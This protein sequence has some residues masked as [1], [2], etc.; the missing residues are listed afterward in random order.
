MAEALRLDP[1]SA[2]KPWPSACRLADQS[3]E[4]GVPVSRRGGRRRAGAEGLRRR[5][6]RAQRVRVTCA[7]PHRR[8]DA[9]GRGVRGRRPRRLDARRAG[10]A[11][12]RVSR[13]R[14]LA[15]SA[16]HQRGPGRP[17]AV[18]HARTSIA[19]AARST[20]LGEPRPGHDHRRATERREPV[21]GGRQD[22]SATKACSS[23]S[24][25]PRV[26]PAPAPPKPP[27]APA[28]SDDEDV[29]DLER[30]CSRNPPLAPA[31]PAP[32]A[33]APPP[34]RRARS[35]TAAPTRTLTQAFKEMRDEV[36]TGSEEEAAAEQFS[37]AQTYRE[38][39]MIDDAIEA[40]KAAVR[41]PRQRFDAACLLGSLHV[42]R[43]ELQSA[44]EW[45]E[46][47]AEVPAPS[48][49]AGRASDVRLGQ[50]A[51]EGRRAVARARG[52]RRARSRIRQL[53]RRGVQD[54]AIVEAPGQ[55]VIRPVQTSSLRR[56]APR[57]RPAADPDSVVGVLGTELLRRSTAASRALLT[58]NFVRGA[59]SGLGLVNVLAAVA[60]LADH[61]WRAGAAGR[62]WRTRRAS[63]AITMRPEPPGGA[64]AVRHGKPS[65]PAAD[66]MPRSPIDAVSTGA[67]GIAGEQ[68]RA[69]LL[70]QI[71]APIAGGIDVV[72]IRERD[73]DDRV[74]SRHSSATVCARAAG[75][76]TRIV[77]NNRIDVARA[78]G[79][80]G[81]HLREDGIAPAAARRLAASP[82]LIG[83]SVHSA[84]AALASDGRGLPDRRAGVRDALESQVTPGMGVE[85]F[86]GIAAAAPCPGMGRR[87]DHAG[88]R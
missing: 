64:P 61:V 22:G 39:G 47:A 37:L 70:Q 4:S 7:E 50:H 32:V 79:A 75:T 12:R 73:L 57:S 10:A 76:R 40:L 1:T 5:R 27:A 69:A 87:R 16:H 2:T 26:E 63:S 74:L 28:A 38:L 84:D 44:I 51:R 21:H 34:G 65:E 80:H 25:K 15:G 54:P 48:A 77:V 82:F 56:P 62:A 33:A 43:D 66:V 53:P 8:A 18:G 35:R 67:L 24:P 36:D 49:A 17:R 23:T 86:P 20:E 13:Q 42:E 72:Q 81:V 83:R 11:G 30:R 85:A 52:V 45:F 29:I 6:Q 9:A 60:E 19:S 68:W 55:R 71:P 46:R 88:A 3:P 41:S 58:N 59:V 78:C 31:P 14:A